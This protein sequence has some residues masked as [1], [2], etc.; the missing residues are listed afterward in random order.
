MF[1]GEGYATKVQQPG[2]YL[3][4]AVSAGCGGA[5]P[6]TPPQCKVTGTLHGPS[7]NNDHSSLVGYTGCIPN[8][9]ILVS[10][11]HQFYK[12][13]GVNIN[14]AKASTTPVGQGHFHAPKQAYAEKHTRTYTLA[15]SL[16]QTQ[17]HSRTRNCT[18]IQENTSKLPRDRSAS[19]SK[20][21]PVTET[22]STIR[23]PKRNPK[24]P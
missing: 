16:S 19:T 14:D 6:P 2:M 21:N 15:H 3:L 5:A 18:R 9:H 17:T 22:S 4:K 13:V 24:N 11:D 8:M 10:Y 7:V 1:K 23:N 12:L 20:P